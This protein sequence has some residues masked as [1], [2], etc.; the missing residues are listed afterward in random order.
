MVEVAGYNQNPTHNQYLEILRLFAILTSCFG[1][2][3]GISNNEI[4]KLY[5]L[6]IRNS[7]RIL[8]CVEIVFWCSTSKIQNFIN[9]IIVDTLNVKN[10]NF[11]TFYVKIIDPLCEYF[12]RHTQF[13][14]N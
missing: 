4:V 10:N 14:F 1:V 12:Q 9:P 3:C 13:K 2:G 11:A 6:C 5:N 8:W 7:Q